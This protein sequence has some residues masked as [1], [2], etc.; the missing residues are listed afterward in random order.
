[1]APGSGPLGAAP[2]IATAAQALAA[3]VQALAAAVQV[4]AAA[5]QVLVAAAQVLAWALIAAPEADTA[6]PTSPAAKGLAGTDGAAV[7]VAMAV[8]VPAT[9]STPD[10]FVIAAAKSG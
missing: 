6:A 1:M 4:L 5:A 2:P 10:A 9:D 8:A 3:A 7:D